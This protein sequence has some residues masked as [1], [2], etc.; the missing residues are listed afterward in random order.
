MAFV[1]TSALPGWKLGKWTKLSSTMWQ[2]QK[3]DNPK[4]VYQFQVVGGPS[5][6]GS[7]TIRLKMKDQN[8]EVLLLESSIQVFSNAGYLGEYIGSWQGSPG[9]APVQQSAPPR[10]PSAGYSAAGPEAQPSRTSASLEKTINP[11]AAAQKNAP[12]KSSEERSSRGRQGSSVAPALP[13]PSA[14]PFESAPMP[15]SDPSRPQKPAG[16]DKS[17]D[18][19]QK[20]CDAAKNGD[21]DKVRQLLADGVDPDGPAKDGRT[22]LMAA[23]AGGHVR[24]V[25]ALL[26][27]FADPTMGKGSE[28]PLTIAFQKGN[29]EILK[30]LF[31]GSFATL[32]N[33][34]SSS[35]AALGAGTSSFTQSVGGGDVPG[36]AMD[37]LRD[38]TS[39]LAGMNRR[40][41]SPERHVR[42]GNYAD[43][44]AGVTNDESDMMRDETIKMTMRNLAKNAKA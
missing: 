20:L 37:D 33:T 23:T 6:P 4:L 32:N 41:I 40:E 42:G 24:V 31:A 29:Q 27:A 39:K 8:T 15:E 43:K 9:N 44:H 14:A 26:E 3:L 17:P 22:P 35:T 11:A 30:K 5:V 16:L 10:R 12:L 34:V 19:M 1:A 21:V 28:T 38:V 36:S 13:P 2:E 18:K 7:N 25:D